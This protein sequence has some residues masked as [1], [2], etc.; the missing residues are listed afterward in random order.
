MG[1]NEG[2]SV[3]ENQLSHVRT[4]LALCR[5]GLTSKVRTL[6]PWEQMRVLN[7]SCLQSRELLL[8]YSLCL[9][10]EPGLAQC[11]ELSLLGLRKE[12]W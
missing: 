6:V 4:L 3:P 5:A 7:G 1:G 2:K 11:S 9:N 12:G 10:P 8:C